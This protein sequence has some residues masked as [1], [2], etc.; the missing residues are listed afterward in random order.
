MTAPSSHR[1]RAHAG[2]PVVEVRR[3]ETFRVRWANGASWSGYDTA[4][5][6]DAAVAALPHR[7]GT[8]ERATWTVELT[9]AFQQ[10]Y[11]PGVTEAAHLEALERFPMRGA[12]SDDYQTFHSEITTTTTEET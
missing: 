1:Y 11:R 6:A 8:V 12:G 3:F 9:E 5:E 2:G 4:G 7:A 10:A